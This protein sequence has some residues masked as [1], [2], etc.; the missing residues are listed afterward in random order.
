MSDPGGSVLIGES[1]LIGRRKR[2]FRGEKRKKA[3]EA[4]YA[5]AKRSLLFHPCKHDTAK[6]AC[7]KFRSRDMKIFHSKFYKFPDKIR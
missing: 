1:K 2:I 3:E 5:S 7:S 4:R 6:F